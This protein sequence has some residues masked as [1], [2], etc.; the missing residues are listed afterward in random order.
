[1]TLW[2]SG[3]GVKDGRSLVEGIAD[4]A[5]LVRLVA[6]IGRD[7]EREMKGEREMRRK[8]GQEECVV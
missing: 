1:M 5:A 8:S 3:T 2:P 4:G 6:S 7:D